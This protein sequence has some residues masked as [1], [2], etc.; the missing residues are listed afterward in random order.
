VNQIQLEGREKRKKISDSC[1]V[2]ATLHNALLKHDDF[3]VFSLQTNC[4]AF[5]SFSK[6][7]FLYPLHW[8]F[9][10][11]V[12]KFHLPPQKKNY[13]RMMITLVAS[14]IEE[15]NMVEKHTIHPIIIIWASCWSMLLMKI[16][17]C[18]TY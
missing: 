16:N 15:K 10:H 9:C 3:K 13:L 7:N 2:L 11:R 12:V 1:F 17:G 14:Q 8:I 6:T 4:D 5:G 18:N